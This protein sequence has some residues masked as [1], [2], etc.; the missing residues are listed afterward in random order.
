M[1]N[2]LRLAGRVLVTLVIIVAAI[3]VGR[4]L[5]NHYMEEPWTPDGHI[6]ADVVDIAPDV[7]G[8]VSD[9]LVH[10]NEVVKKGDVLFR[11]D[12]QR[13][14]IAVA[15]AEA[16][17]KGRQATLAQARRDRQRLE[18][19]TTFVSNQ[20]REQAEAAEAEAEASYEQSLADLDLA[21]LNLTR[22]EVK[23]PVNGVITNFTLRPGDYVSSGKA[24]VA[25]L[26]SDTIRVEGYFEETKLPRIKI[27]DPARIMLM[28]RGQPLRG[29][30]E[31]IAAGIAE[32]DRSDS[33]D[34]LA[35]VNPTFSWVRLAQRVPVRIAFDSIPPD[36]RLIGGLTATVTIEP[37]V[38]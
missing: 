32:Q 10:D 27:G 21:R 2:S 18:K 8:L 35:S 16:V 11:V 29:H 36:I 17:A 26:D 25:L 14:R 4:G 31:S 23:A 7:S 1:K 5:W 38:H 33:S 20:Q 13:F 15:E 12:P 34:L 28:G 6:R 19:L 22:S 24:E 9:V 30:V 37:S 3:F